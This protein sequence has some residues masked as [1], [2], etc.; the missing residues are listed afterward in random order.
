M[1]KSSILAALILGLAGVIASVPVRAES[2]LYDNTGPDSYTFNAFGIQGLF[3]VVDSFT[4]SQNAMVTGVDFAAWVDPGDTL[5]NVD[6]VISS[7][8]SFGFLASGTGA[9]VSGSYYSS[10]SGIYDV[11]EESF[12]TPDL[13]LAAGTYWLELQNAVTSGSSFPYW[14]VSGGPSQAWQVIDGSYLGGGTMPSETFQI[15]GTTAATPEPSSF[16]LLASGMVGLA[17]MVRRKLRA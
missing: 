9:A 8:P 12:S 4:L 10:V 7:G 14:D 1:K 11:D 13:S 16:L 5:T 3:A 15:L 6:W 17:E 2:L